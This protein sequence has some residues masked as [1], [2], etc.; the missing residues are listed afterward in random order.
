MLSEVIFVASHLNI[1]LLDSN[2]LWFFGLCLVLVGVVNLDTVGLLDV[3]SLLDLVIHL[4]QLLL[5]LLFF[6]ILSIFLVF[7]LIVRLSC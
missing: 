6:F 3:L 7:R 5:E 2:F 1:Q 4:F